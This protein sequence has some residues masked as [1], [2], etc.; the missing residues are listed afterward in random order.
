MQSNEFTINSPS[1]NQKIIIAETGATALF[2]LTDVEIA[3]V[4]GWGSELRS[5]NGQIVN[6][7]I[8]EVNGCR[9]FD[10][11]LRACEE[12]NIQNYLNATYM[13]EVQL[14]LTL[15]LILPFQLLA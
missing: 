11:L 9:F 13:L 2:N 5:A 1:A 15:V 14:K 7:T 12:L 8:T 6:L 4:M 3:H 10:Y